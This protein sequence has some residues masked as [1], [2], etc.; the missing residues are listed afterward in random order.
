MDSS[1][2]IEQNQT[3]ASDEISLM[4]MRLSYLVLP[5]SVYE[6]LNNRFLKILYCSEGTFVYLGLYKMK[7]AKKMYWFE[8]RQSI[9]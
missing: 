3:V 8:I 4:M 9:K 7:L 2:T 1:P 6:K 5:V